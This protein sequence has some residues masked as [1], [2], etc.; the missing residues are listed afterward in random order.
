M[1]VALIILISKFSEVYLSN[2]ND[3]HRLAINA[4]ESFCSQ[5]IHW[6]TIYKSHPQPGQPGALK[7]GF[8][9]SDLSGDFIVVD[10]RTFDVEHP[11]DK[12]ELANK[13]Y[14]TL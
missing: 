13:G 14:F 9:M 10:S 7:N 5:S 3:H 4:A 8:V 1:V 2:E 11:L 6:N 12:I